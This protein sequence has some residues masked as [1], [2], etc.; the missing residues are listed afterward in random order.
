MSLMKCP[1]CS[2]VIVASGDG[3]CPSCGLALVATQTS[4]PVP[5][6]SLARHA[7]VTDDQLWDYVRD[8][9]S[10]EA[11]DRLEIHV[12]ACAACEERLRVLSQFGRQPDD[13]ADLV[14]TV[15]G[16]AAPEG[17]PASADEPVPGEIGN[18]VVGER[19]GRGAFGEVYRAENPKLARSV[20]IKFLKR[21]TTRR[22]KRQRVTDEEYRRRIEEFRREAAVLAGLKHPHIITVYDADELPDGRWYVVS[23]FIDQGNLAERIAQ[24]RPSPQE[25]A[26]IV[27]TVAEALHYAHGQ[28]LVHRDIKPTNILLDAAGT[29]HLADFGLALSDEDY[30]DS[31]AVQGG[32]PSY[33]SPEQARREGHLVDNRSDIFSLGVVFYELLT[34]RRPF[35]GRDVP[36]LL[37]RIASNLGARPPRMLDDTIPKELER[38]CLKALEKRQSDRYTTAKDLAEELRLALLDRPSAAQP[39][40]AAA[41]P[42]AAGSDAAGSAARAVAESHPTIIP[43]GLR[44]FDEN[45]ADF[46]LE[47]LPGPRDRAGLPESIRFWKNRIE[48]READKSFRVGLVYGPSGCGKSSLVQAGLLPKL[49]ESVLVVDIEADAVDTERRLLRRLYKKIPHLPQ[50]LG[51]VD[52]FAFLRRSQAEPGRKTLVVFDQFE[53]WLHARAGGD[54]SDLLHALRQCDGERLQALLLIRDDFWMAASR[55][56]HRLEVPIVEGSNSA[57]VDLFDP[58]HARKVLGEFGRAWG[59]LPGGSAD[60]TAEQCHF[61]DHAIAELAQD[62]LVMPVRL[63]LFA[64]MIKNKPWLLATLRTLGGT[65]GVSI[66]FLEETFSAA[67]APPEHH[68]HQRGAQ[69]VLKHLLPRGSVD[70]TGQMRSQTELR[71][72]AGYAD[73]PAEFDQLLR[74]LDSE[75]RLL[76]PIDP[77]L[78]A[79]A[80]SQDQELARPEKYYRLTHDYLVPALRTWLTRKQKE[81]WRGRAQLQLAERAAMWHARPEP[82]Q[83]PTWWEWLSVNLLTRAQDRTAHEQRMMRVAGRRLLRQASVISAALVLVSALSAYWYGRSTA[84][85]LVQGLLT[86]EVDQLPAIVRKVPR[87]RYWADDM[88]RAVLEDPQRDDRWR[89]QL[90]LLPRDPQQ[91]PPLAEQ[92][93]SSSGA[94]FVVLRDALAPYQTRLAEEL[95]QAAGGGDPRAFTAACAL[96]QYAPRDARWGELAPQVARQ[97]AAKN[98]LVLAD[99]AARLRPVKEQLRATLVDLA[100]DPAKAAPGP[101]AEAVGIL[102]DYFPDDVPLLVELMVHK[103][104]VDLQVLTLLA[105]EEERSRAQAIPLLEA[106]LRAQPPTA[107]AEREEFAQRQASAAAAL[108]RLGRPEHLWRLLR[109]QPDPR[110]RTYLIHGLAPAEVSPTE[111]G[112]RLPLEP[113]PGVQQALILALG[114]YQRQRLPAADLAMLT[115]Q[116]QERCEQAPDAGVRSAAE[117]LL[118][119]WG[120]TAEAAA[121]K[122]RLATGAP[123]GDRKWYVTKNGFHTMVLL[124]PTEPFWIGAP[125]NDPEKEG[126]WEDPLLRIIPRKFAIASQEVTLRQMQAHRPDFE[127]VYPAY[128][129]SPDCPVTNVTWYDAARYCN[130]LSRSDGLT[131]GDLCYI[132]NDQ[133]QIVNVAPDYLSRIGYRLPTEAE[134]EYACRARTDTS[135]EYTSRYYGDSVEMLRHYEAFLTTTAPQPPSVVGSFKPN[136][137]GLFDM[138][139][140]VAEWCHEHPDDDDRKQLI[141]QAEAEAEAVPDAEVRESTLDASRAVRGG[142]FSSLSDLC[143][144]P[145]RHTAMPRQTYSQTGFRPTRTVRE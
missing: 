113:D 60:P 12:E 56:M 97:L 140:N 63:A 43:K 73:R 133:G 118:G 49:A 102:I 62:G 53:Q 2:T 72:V 80:A 92:L 51:L 58:L 19:L 94:Q 136:D 31:T 105:E 74:I 143:R 144:S 95:W 42:T 11:N 8:K 50:G 91:L 20:A 122:A 76:T 52:A 121:I 132:E 128:T 135:R 77:E 36:D 17:D 33:M 117:W 86:S 10:P 24:D 69:A 115:A 21:T 75:T 71:E 46:F 96:A 1:A 59:R 110:T 89:A 22:G 55:F 35:V 84:R 93:L 109:R 114:E 103:S 83:L 28:L 38:I 104:P 40:A 3:R 48:Q 108:F 67:T 131:V 7:C 106:M 26:E 65:E 41:R 16:K 100:K 129:P 134:W 139:G 79:A 123:L 4:L 18:Y 119:Q 13:A 5:T 32:T 98:A 101:R 39:A 57:A 99:A 87:F 6:N 125:D 107:V 45:D 68:W 85:A 9:L 34:G 37:Q 61:L 25:A 27:A 66:T 64:E 138:L 130:W 78:V 90:A 145:S 44:S 15:S 126:A 141:Q 23:E 120:G 81:S 88:L 127:L 124:G 29:P 54:E 30:G 14:D 111:L 70:L 112:K 47:L 137:F 82:R 142:S 116:L